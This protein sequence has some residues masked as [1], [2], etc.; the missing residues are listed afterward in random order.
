MSKVKQA[1]VALLQDKAKLHQAL[2]SKHVIPN[3]PIDKTSYTVVDS[4]CTLGIVNRGWTVI[5]RYPKKHKDHEGKLRHM[6]D[7]VATIIRPFGECRRLLVAQVNHVLYIP[8]ED[9]SLLPPNQMEWNDLTV[10]ATPLAFGGNQDIFGK[11]F[12]IPFYWI[13]STTIF[14]HGSVKDNDFKL[15]CCHLISSLLYF[16]S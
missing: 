2:E 13:G 1:S 6:V 16:P 4:G 15:S 9:E 7:A 5:K 12:T 8:E 11:G 10:D 3:L 14:N